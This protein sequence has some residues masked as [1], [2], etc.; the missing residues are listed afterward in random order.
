MAKSKAF[1]L[2]HHVFQVGIVLKGLNGLAEI[3]GGIFILNVSASQI[4]GWIHHIF[5]PWV[6]KNPLS[7]I[8]NTALRYSER[9]TQSGQDFAGWYF[10]SHGIIKALIVVCLLKGWRWAY[11]LAIA[12]FLGFIGFQ[13]WEYF[14]ASHSGFYIF[15]DVFDGLIIALTV[16]EWRHAAQAAR[17]KQALAG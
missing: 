10:L 17:E 3:I 7:W 6:Q 4:K 13:T 14:T 5:E 16:M 12:V 15:L 9:I 8:A 11:P 2:F 1:S